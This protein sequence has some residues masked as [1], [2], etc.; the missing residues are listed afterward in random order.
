MQRLQ[1]LLATKAR[2][3][4]KALRLTVEAGGCSGFSYRCVRV[5]VTTNE[6]LWYHT[7]WDVHHCFPNI[8]MTGLINAR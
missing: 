4:E 8:D 6:Q 1:H 3:D 2:P 5:S 7:D